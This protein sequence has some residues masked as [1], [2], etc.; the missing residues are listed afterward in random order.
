MT[1]LN[2][3]RHAVKAFRFVRCEFSADSGVAKEGLGVARF[4]D[5]AAQIRQVL[6]EVCLERR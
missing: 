4:A 6:R 1:E 3:D 5:R 2:F